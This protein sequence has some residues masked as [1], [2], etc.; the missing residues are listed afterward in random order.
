MSFCTVDYDGNYDN[1]AS[2]LREK[3]P[4]CE[5]SKSNNNKILVKLPNSDEKDEL[6]F[7]STFTLDDQI[8]NIFKVNKKGK[9][10]V[11]KP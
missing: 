10:I 7:F 4:S 8:S 2:F 5:V 9:N 6:M 11:E 1:I 3:V